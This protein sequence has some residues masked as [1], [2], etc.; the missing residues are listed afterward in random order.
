MM[1]NQWKKG[2]YAWE[3]ATAEY[4]E[5]V[6]K[7]PSVLGPSGQMLQGAMKA[8]AAGSDALAQFW[9]GWGLPTKRDQE[10]SLHALN[11]IQSKL[12]DME[13][14]VMELEAEL[15]KA[16]T[17]QPAPAAAKA[18]RARSRAAKKTTKKD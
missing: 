8:R 16:R 9:G 3:N 15:V 5:T 11:Q 17:A 12:I 1:W 14:R 13:E 2:F 4:L 6:L 7:N 10:R 18:P